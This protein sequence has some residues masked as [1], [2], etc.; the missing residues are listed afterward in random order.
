MKPALAFTALVLTVAAGIAGLY[1]AGPK[2]K[3]TNTPC[4]QSSSRSSGGRPLCRYKRT[5]PF[6]RIKGGAT[7]LHDTR[8]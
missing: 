1:A 3:A 2:T 5:N 4:T 8:H 6:E 7:D